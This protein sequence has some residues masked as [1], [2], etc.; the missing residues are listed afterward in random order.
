MIK[1]KCLKCKKEFLWE[2]IKENLK[3]CIYCTG[4]SFKF[5]GIGELLDIEESSNIKH[6][7]DE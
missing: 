6:T 5:M 4:T 1:V 3:N 2:G 7:E